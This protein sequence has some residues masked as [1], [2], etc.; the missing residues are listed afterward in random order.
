[1]TLKNLL[2]D[3]TKNIKFT[4]VYVHRKDLVFVR[5]IVK[6]LDSE[7]VNHAII[8]RW[9]QGEWGHY[10]I[11]TVIT[12]HCVIGNGD[13]RE[14]LS[15]GADGTVHVASSSGFK[16]ECIDHSDE[17]PNDKRAMVD[18]KPVGDTVFAVGMARQV[19]KRQKAGLW[20]RCD[21]GARGARKK[22]EIAGFKSVDGF[23][24]KSV[25]AVGFKGEIW[26][27]E[28]SRWQQLDS[29]T[30]IKLER[31]KCVPPNNIFISGARGTFIK[32][33][34]NQWTIVPN[35]LT[36]STLWGLEYFNEKVYLSDRKKVYVFYGTDIMNVDMQLG[37]EVT[38]CYLH[39]NDGVLWSVGDKDIVVFD[40]TSWTEIL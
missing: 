37:R 21:Q 39:A 8:L 9:F 26:F 22:W 6:S 38:T 12:S 23:G 40:G 35:D 2:G 29:P 3:V 4:G 24:P 18:I 15:L 28:G 17:G 11:E 25:Y 19:Y 27:F 13:S 16:W 30:N 36:N 20:I 10:I 31:I 5:C 7:D 34:N 32:A 1:M 14:V 33:G